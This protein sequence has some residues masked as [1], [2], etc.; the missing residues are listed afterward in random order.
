[1]GREVVGAKR[2]VTASQKSIAGNPSVRKAHSNE[3]TSDSVEE[4]AVADCAL[5]NADRVAKVLGPAIA[6]KKLDV[7]LLKSALLPAKSASV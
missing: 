1:M 6:K 5:L 4:C 7:H 3:M 2:G